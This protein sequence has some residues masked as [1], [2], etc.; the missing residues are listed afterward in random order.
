MDALFAALGLVFIAELGDKTQLIVLGMG[1]RHRA[2]P[3]IA[4]LAIGF[5]ISN[6]LAAVVGGLA[7]A[8]LPTRTL[9]IAGG[10]LF[11]VFAAVGLWRLFT[12]APA[13]PDG[14]TSDRD[15]NAAED[16]DELPG[17]TGQRMATGRVI[18]SVASMIVIGELG[19]KTQLA[20]ATLAAQ[21]APVLVW[22]GSTLGVVAASLA[23]VAVGRAMG[24]R[25][26]ERAVH[27]L[28]SILFGVFGVV[29]IA[30]NV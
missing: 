9:G 7:G 2:A 12:A 21:N 14:D 15:A 19:D 30:V 20:T 11:L 3:V 4:G 5:G 26:P 29:M 22:A 6:L 27:L 28:S 24:R 25:L 1:A 17:S 18:T 8:A 13:D 16:G 10:V 23:A